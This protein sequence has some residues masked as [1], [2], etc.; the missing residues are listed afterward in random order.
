MSMDDTICN[1][2]EPK[3]I[4]PIDYTDLS[5]IVNRLDTDSFYSILALPKCLKRIVGNDC[6]NPK[7]IDEQY[8]ELNVKN[9]TI[10]AITIPVQK[11]E[12][13]NAVRG[14]S[15][16][17]IEEYPDITVSIKLD[18]NLYNY[19]LLYR[20]ISMLVDEEGYPSDLGK[21][22]YATSY[23]VLLLNQYEEAIG[24]FTYHEVI[25]VSVGG[26]EFDYTT[27]DAIFIDFTFSYDYISFDFVAKEYK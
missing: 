20:W 16:K 26:I 3:P 6:G 19:N 22:D 15:S 11:V 21:E 4:Y 23:T 1:P 24:T 2:P 17:K 8:I 27:S 13:M 18:S 9:V 7:L 5:S 10:P 12:Y 14:E 25:P